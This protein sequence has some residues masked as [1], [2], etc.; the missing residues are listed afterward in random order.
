MALFESIYSSYLSSDVWDVRTRLHPN[1][2][3]SIFRRRRQGCVSTDCTAY[4]NLRLRKSMTANRTQ[5]G[6]FL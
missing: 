3:I 4:S 6:L 1:G 2:Y 5:Q